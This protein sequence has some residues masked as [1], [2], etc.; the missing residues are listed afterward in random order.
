M[1]DQ[2]M[3]TTGFCLFVCCF[4]VSYQHKGYVTPTM[5]THHLITAIASQVHDH[6]NAL[7][8]MSVFESNELIKIY[9]G[10]Q[11]REKN[12]FTRES[13]SPQSTAIFSM[14]IAQGLALV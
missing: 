6:S 7:S 10:Q 4:Y 9:I 13:H 3:S 14:W 11:I 12:L 8:S 1:L 2:K 5:I